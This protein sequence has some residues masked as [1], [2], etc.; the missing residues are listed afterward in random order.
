VSDQPAPLSDAEIEAETFHAWHA[1]HCPN[2]SFGRVW[3]TLLAERTLRQAAERAL[4]AEMTERAERAE[5]VLADQAQQM[6]EDIT[7]RHA[8]ERRLAQERQAREQVEAQ[9]SLSEQTMT[10]VL[11]GQ[12]VV[13]ASVNLDPALL[14]QWEESRAALAACEARLAEA[15]RLCHLCKGTKRIRPSVFEDDVFIGHEPE[16]PCPNP[17]H[18]QP[19]HGLGEA[20]RAPRVPSVG[21][22]RAEEETG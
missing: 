19:A 10:E 22:A 8:V 20:Q 9:L 1:E 3:I 11:N 14:Q 12:R 17:I 2:C 21:A 6:R 16:Q 15:E 4:L 5:S 13:S 7:R 18:A